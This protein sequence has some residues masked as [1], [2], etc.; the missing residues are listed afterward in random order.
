M[1]RT[2]PCRVRPLRR[3]P[4]LIISDLPCDR[5]RPTQGLPGPSGPEPPEE[6]EM[7]PERVPR[8]RAPKVPKECAPES[9][10]SPKRV[11][12]SGFRLFS[13]SFETAGAT[14][15][16]HFWGPFSGVLSP[17]SFQTLPGCRARRARETLCG[18]GPIARLA[19]VGL[20]A[21]STFF[22]NELA[23]NYTHTYTPQLMWSYF[24]AG[25][26]G[27]LPASSSSSSSFSVFISKIYTCTLNIF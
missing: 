13:D 11:R 7:S 4:Y 1:P 20:H 6:S 23:Q 8:Y 22:L 15:F 10:K 5:P 12:K 14:L 9:Q 17:H 3:A 27:A 21:P 16:R 25:C 26:N 18:A 19:I 2:P 24:R